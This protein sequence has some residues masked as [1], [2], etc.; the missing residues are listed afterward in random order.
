MLLQVRR[1]VHSYIAQVIICSS[2]LL[3]GLL[4]GIKMVVEC[5][6]GCDR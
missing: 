3:D 5:I 2:I 6:R 4:K 1:S